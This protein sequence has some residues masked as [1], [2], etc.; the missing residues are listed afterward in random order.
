MNLAS[1]CSRPLGTV[2]VV[3][4]TVLYSG[5]RLVPLFSASYAGPETW[6]GVVGFAVAYLLW[7]GFLVG[8]VAAIALYT[9]LV[10]D[11]ALGVAV[12]GLTRLPHVVVAFVVLAYLVSAHERFRTVPSSSE[13]TGTDPDRINCPS[14]G[15]RNSVTDEECHYCGSPL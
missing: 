6:A 9:L 5:A 4:L 11:L 15:S 1:V 2:G 8:W 13:G 14:C 7:R 12:F 3:L 10:F